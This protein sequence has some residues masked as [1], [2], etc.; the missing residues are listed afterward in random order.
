M[1]NIVH[2]NLK[3]GTDLMSSIHSLFR[4]EMSTNSPTAEARTMHLRDPDE[5]LLTRESLES[6]VIKGWSKNHAKYNEGV[7]HITSEELDGRKSYTNFR[8][9]K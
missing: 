4:K 2:T 5:Y 9:H 3:P 6:S 7:L 8:K 1:I